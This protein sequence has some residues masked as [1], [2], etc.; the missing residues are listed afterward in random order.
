MTIQVDLNVWEQFKV[1]NLDI[2]ALQFTLVAYS[3]FVEGL[4]SI[5]FVGKVVHT[6]LVCVVKISYQ[7]KKL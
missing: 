1:Q 5:I 4:F 2:F 3:F 7:S 6:S